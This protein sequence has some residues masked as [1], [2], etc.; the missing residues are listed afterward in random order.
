LDYVGL[1]FADPA[2]V[3]YEYKLEGYNKDWVNAGTRRQAF[4]SNLRP[5]AYQFRV[6][7]CNNDGLWSEDGEVVE[8][9]VAPAIY[10]TA[11]FLALC[12]AA[13][14]L[15]V[16]GLYRLR[17][18]RLA[19]SM[20]LQ[21]AAEQ[22]ERRRIAQELHDTLLQGFTGVGLKLDALTNSLPASLNATKE[23]FQKALQQIDQYLAEG[24]RS[25]WKLR[26]PTLESAGDFSN[27]L[28]K[29]SKRALDG[30][31][32][33]LRF[34]VQGQARKLKDFFEDNLLRIC[35]EAVANSV[36]HARPT[37]IEVTLEFN[38]KDVQLRIRDNGCGFDAK[39]IERSKHGHFGLVGI[40]E[41]VQSMGGTFL[42]NS[43]PGVGTDIAV[44]IRT[45]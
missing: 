6:R 8:F 17:L 9:S 21:L 12:L 14:G 33:A 4:Y 32:I 30:T 25:V 22:N 42:L 38:C 27:A 34:S 11:W 13:F 28:E 10:E 36:K 19:A 44:T 40:Q 20:D 15:G 29:T 45:E 5:K 24:R 31:V 23:Q 16:F 41:R 26:S 18:R 3:R 1:S 37:Q 39:Q 2:G 43:Q 35:E 7:A